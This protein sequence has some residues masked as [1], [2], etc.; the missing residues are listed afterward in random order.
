MDIL[1]DHDDHKSVRHW[2]HEDINIRNHKSRKYK[3]YDFNDWF[4]RIHSFTDRNESKRITIPV[5]IPF[6]IMRKR[7][8]TPRNRTQVIHRGGSGSKRIEQVR[9]SLDSLKLLHSPALIDLPPLD[10]VPLIFSFSFYS[11]PI[12]IH[13]GVVLGFHYLKAIGRSQNKIKQ[14]IVFPSRSPFPLRRYFELNWD[15]VRPDGSDL[16]RSKRWLVSSPP[17]LSL[18]GSE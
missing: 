10:G 18:E 12:C 7:S 15:R 3:P 16:G 14:G 13:F 6:V 11:P 4:S 1:R 2:L 17:L 9:G 5:V 8:F